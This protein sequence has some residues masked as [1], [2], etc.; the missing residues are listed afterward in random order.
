[1]KRTV[2]FIGFLAFA[3]LLQLL[4]AGLS[5][6]SVPINLLFVLTLTWGYF[7]GWKEGLVV[8]FISGLT[9]D[10]FFFPVIGIHA[11]SFLL[12]GLVAGEIRPRIYQQ[13]VLFFALTAAPLYLLN[14]FI[15]STFTAVV[16]QLS[17]GQTFMAVVYPDLIWT[18]VACCVV[19]ISI[20]LLRPQLN[21]A[22]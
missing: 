8:G 15:V 11:F 2:V 19:F 20:A 5:T 6:Q 4:I 10:F 1:M 17:F 12:V 7:R 16:S 22:P 13:N 18:T 9:K 21:A 14:T 3:V